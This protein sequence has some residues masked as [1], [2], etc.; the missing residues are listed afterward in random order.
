MKIVV[1]TSGEYSYYGIIGIMGAPDNAEPKADQEAFWNAVDAVTNPV[2]PVPEPPPDLAGRALRKWKGRQEQAHHRS[3]AI[4]R[5][6]ALLTLGTELGHDVSDL[7]SAE[8][9]EPCFAWMKCGH[10]AVRFLVPWLI[11]HRGYQSFEY[12]EIYE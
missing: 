4:A 7:E 6:A 12:V 9:I 8:E 2:L 11:A 1:I 10:I 5:Y 3:I